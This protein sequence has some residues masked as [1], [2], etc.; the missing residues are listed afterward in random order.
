M[1]RLLPLLLMCLLLCACSR[2]PL[3]PMAD[4]APADVPVP[5]VEGMPVE[6]HQAVLWFRFGTEPCLAAEIR[7]ISLTQTQSYPLALLTALLE[8]PSASAT[9]L[10]AVFPQGTR[11]LSVTQSGK[12]MFV[13][14]SRHILNSYADEPA[15]WRSHPAW[16]AEVPLRRQLAMQSIVATLTENCSVDQVIILVEQ[17]GA[18]T[19]SLRLRT[20]YY[21]LDGNTALADPLLRDES[22]LL[23]PARTAEVILQCWQEADWARLYLYVARTDPATGAQ[24]PSESDF[25][26]AMSAS[27]RLTQASAQGGSIT[28][29]S[30]IFTVSG[31]WLSGG[32]EQPFSGMTL[33]LVQEKGLWR[34]GISQ[35][36][37]REALP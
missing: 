19:D 5:A 22:L 18:A 29:S 32:A 14:L 35:L 7:S 10:N 33:R 8:G 13:T 11:V 36:T 21:T 34:V 6:D 26:A 3:S 24:R 37:G 4:P 27:P 15:D 30:A 31:A 1:R 28:G 25:A 16:A 9:E 17:S 12:T 20:G 23:T 2:D